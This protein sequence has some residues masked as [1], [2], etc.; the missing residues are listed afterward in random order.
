MASPAA[1]DAAPPP[2]AA[3]PVLFAR[4]PARQLCVAAAVWRF[5][6]KDVV[7]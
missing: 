5:D 2:A 6:R 7:S 1:A 4:L 3:L